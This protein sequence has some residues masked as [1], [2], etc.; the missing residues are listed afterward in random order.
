MTENMPPEFSKLMESQPV[1]YILGY[2]KKATTDIA[3]LKFH[4]AMPKNNIICW[5]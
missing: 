3:H 4:V 1:A 2:W 5:V